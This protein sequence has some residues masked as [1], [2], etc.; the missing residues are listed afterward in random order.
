MKKVFFK[1]ALPVALSMAMAFNMTAFTKSV[2]AEEQQEGDDGYSLVWSEEFDGD[3]LNTD[4][5]NV[6]QHEPGWVNNELQRYTA[7]DEGNIEVSEGTLKIKPHVEGGETKE[8]NAEEEVAV[9]IVKTDISFDISVPENKATSTGAIQ[10]N[11]GKIDDTAEGQAPG[12]ILVSDI[13]LKDITEGADNDAELLASDWSFGANAPGEGTIEYVEQGMKVNVVSAGDANWNIQIQQS[14]VSLEA[15]HSYRF[16]LKAAADV[17][18]KIELSILDPNNNYYWYGGSVASLTA[19][20]F[21]GSQGGSAASDRKITSGRITT[22]GKHDFTYGRF[23]TRAKVPV[24]RGYLPAFWLMATNESFYGQWPRCGEIDIMEVMGQNVSKS[25]HT[26]HYGYDS[27]TGHKEN[28]G[29][30]VLKDSNYADEYHVFAVD[31]EPGLITWYV[32]GEKV[33]ETNDWYTGTDDDNQVTYPAPFDQNFYV[34]LNLAVGGSWVGFPDDA[35]YEAM[36]EQKFEVDYVRVYQK[37]QEEY[38]RLENEAKRPEKV[39]KSFREADE[40]G[41]YVINGD[42]SQAITFEGAEGDVDDNFKLHLESDA[43]GTEFAINNGEIVITPSVVGEQNYSIQL[44]QPGIPMHKGW[45]Y[46]LS[47]DAY[48]TED[49]DIVVDVEG[50]DRS[51][52]RYMQDTN[53]SLSTEKKNYT[54]TFT[55]NEKSDVNGCLEFNLGKLGSTAAVALSNIRLTH[56]SGEE[57]KEDNLKTV[58]PDGNYVYNG[59]FDQGDKRL[60]YWEISEE[61]A[62]YVSVVNA[63]GKRELKVTV[64]EGQ[65][66]KVA[67][68]KLSPIVRGKYELSFD[69][70]NEEGNGS[71]SVDVAGNAFEAKAT[72]E[73]SSFAKKL[74]ITE[75]KDRDV[76]YVAFHF[77]EAG[78][79][80]IDNVFLTEAALIK[81]GS[82]NAGLAG[83]SPYIHDSVTANYVIDSMNGND[84]AFAITIEDTVSDTADNDWYVQLNQDGITLEQGKTYR[85]SFMAKSSIDRTIKYCMQQFEG[86]WT[87]YSNTGSVQIGNE[88]KTFTSEFTMNSPTDTKSRFNITMGSVDGVR[89]TQ[90]HDVYIDNIVLEEVE[91]E[92]PSQPADPE[93]PTDPEEPSPEDPTD[94]DQPVDPQPGDEP[95]EPT[96]P[97]KP[98]GTLITKWGSTYYVDADGNKLTGFREI[99]GATYYFKEKSGSM[100]RCD[101]IRLE[102]GTYYALN[103]GK[104]AKSMFV[105]K[106]GST[107]AYDEEGKLRTGLFSIG[108]DLY[109]SNAKG[110]VQRQTWIKVDG[111]KKYYAKADGV[112]ARNETIK[113][114]GSYYS[115][116]ENGIL[117]K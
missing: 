42:F 37:S 32:D 102:D 38:E 83:F 116:D 94:P 28:Q 57:V 11:F 112:L 35:A 84:N 76:S 117:I 86:S 62:Q 115:F 110:S 30:N 67:Q 31:W 85:L 107:Y 24:G 108:D 109:Y 47:F 89:I 105:K 92:N 79:Y 9:E 106:W 60:G 16:S 2:K 12:T 59:A 96:E 18:R 56:K 44:M 114:W 41:N 91:E 69:I 23:E 63:G 103:D 80:Y 3:T 98:E 6:E 10:V 4:D 72:S 51:W 33:F 17:D 99:N 1:R 88:Y 54:L 25:F 26:I 75:D 19:T 15:G 113:K 8:E 73:N 100:V 111:E 55:M 81:N 5:W 61:D 22:Q 101:Y 13:S 52:I 39:E 46:E 21:G 66:V 64:P 104:I 53:V 48:A 27:S 29:F 74:D 90:K 95:T 58:R 71:V 7:L 70:R 34:I 14:G 45:E 49:R 87:N 43:E 82:F 65:I 93:D 77:N 36:N 20:A 68:N 78:T 97:E 40:T 50:P